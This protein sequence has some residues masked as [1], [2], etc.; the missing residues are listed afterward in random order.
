MSTE[1]WL[2][3][4]RAMVMSRTLEE[5]CTELFPHWYAS[6]GEE[7]VLVGTFSDLRAGDLVAPHYRGLMIA[8]WLRGMSLKEIFAGVFCRKSSVSRGRMSGLHAGP[9]E[10]GV[11][12]YVNNVLGP[13]IPTATGMAFAF[14]YRKEDRVAVV[15][16]GDGTAGLGEFHETMNLGN[17]LKAPV[18]YVCQNNQYSISTSSSRSL[19][20]NSISDW[21]SRYRMP[22]VTVDGNDVLAVSEA[23]QAAVAW[24]RAGKGPSFVEAVTYRRSGHFASD[25]A[26]YRP[27][28]EVQS[29]ERHDPIANLETRLVSSGVSAEMLASVWAD[30][31]RAAEEAAAE[32]RAEPEVDIGDLGISEV[33]ERV[34]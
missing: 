31:R 10:R 4:H 21:A 32:A 29:W 1:R 15:A 2:Q 11:L 19:S 28:S 25:A 30:C 16:F 26:R 18:V 7:A 5:Y 24:A 27:A 17:V 23:V 22:A 34:Y 20:C 12:P 6:I 8:F 33:Y 9:I 14:K 13:P 3:W